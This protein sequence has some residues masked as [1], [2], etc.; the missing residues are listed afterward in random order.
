MYL[1]F[2]PQKGRQAWATEWKEENADNF[3][4]K[5][6]RV[7]LCEPMHMQPLLDRSSISENGIGKRIQWKLQLFSKRFKCL[8]R[9]LKL[10]LIMFDLLLG[11]LKL[12]RTYVPLPFGYDS[13]EKLYTSKE[14]R[15]GMVVS[16][17]YLNQCADS[18]RSNNFAIFPIRL[19]VDNVTGTF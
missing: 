15:C 3:F 19:E 13:M 1:L 6:H 2:W 16:I 4:E 17:D 18:N 8:C 9:I 11:T 10:L 14:T 12:D 7:G 5:L